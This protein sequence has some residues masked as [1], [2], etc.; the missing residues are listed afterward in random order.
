MVCHALHDFTFTDKD[1]GKEDIPYYGFQLEH[2]TVTHF[3]ELPAIISESVA[4]LKTKVEE[5][6][7]KGYRMNT[8]GRQNGLLMTTTFPCTTMNNNS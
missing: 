6:D 7:G 5:F 2:S 4:S 3:S 1:S 8:G